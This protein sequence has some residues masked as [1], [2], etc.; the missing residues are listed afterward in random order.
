MR[1]Y[2][3]TVQELVAL[4]L[5]VSEKTG[6]PACHLNLRRNA[7]GKSVVFYASFERPLRVDPCGVVQSTQEDL[8]FRSGY[9]N[10]F[11]GALLPKSH[12]TQPCLKARVERWVS[13][14]LLALCTSYPSMLLVLFAS[15]SLADSSSSGSHVG[16]TPVVKTR[17][18]YCHA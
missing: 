16:G 14:L 11:T 13:H 8:N 7:V 18:L 4:A 1:R 2:K 5:F 9:I 17:L 3:C 15:Y 12:A 6:N 10:M